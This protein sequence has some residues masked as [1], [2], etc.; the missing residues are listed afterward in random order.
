MIGYLIKFE[1]L[2][3][4]EAVEKAAQIG[5]TDMSKMCHSET[6]IFLKSINVFLNRV[7]IRK[8]QNIKFCQTMQ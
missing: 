1:G 5:N 7:E 4:D 8:K 2:D 3:F 6:V